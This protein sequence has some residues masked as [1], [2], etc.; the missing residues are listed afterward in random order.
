[1]IPPQ[2]ELR[3]AA[4]ILNEGEKVAILVGAG[5]AD[6]ADEVVEAADLLGAGVA[7]TSLGRAALLMNCR[8]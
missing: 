3:K 1:M 4:E 8:M 2:N 7:K 6:A 5:A